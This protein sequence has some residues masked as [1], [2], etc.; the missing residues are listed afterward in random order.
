MLQKYHNDSFDR[1]DPAKRAKILSTGIQEFADNGF[2]SSNIN[3]IAKKAGVSVGVMYKYFNSKK[4]FFLTCVQHSV[5]VLETVISDVMAND[6]KLLIKV[7]KLIRAIQYHS[8]ENANFVKLY[9]QITGEGEN[10]YVKML[11]QKIE[12]ISSDAYNVVLKQA[13]EDGDIRT[14]CDPRLFAFFF[15]NLLTSLQ[16]S[17]T[18]E[19]Y[20]E[21]F[22]IYCGEDIFE[23][24]EKVLQELLK[25]FESAFT[26]SKNNP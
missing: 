2:E 4:D 13:I 9:N 12:G 6:D 8:R 16:F 19:Y 18:C 1:I 11:A 5:D 22:K 26:F 24:D 14:D 21:R 20:K 25:F 23:N 17:Y 15:D 10:E 7:E 3:I